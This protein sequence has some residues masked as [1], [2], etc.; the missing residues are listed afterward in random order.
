M[1]SRARH[2]ASIGCQRVKSLCGNLTLNRAA[3]EAVPYKELE[4]ITM[5][6][7]API[8]A[9][10]KVA[11]EEAAGKKINAM[12]GEARNRP[13][14]WGHEKKERFFASLRMTKRTAFFAACE[15]AAHTCDL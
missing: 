12:P 15:A 5:T 4:A 2:P 1:S 9:P 6:L 14:I 3:A 11:A 8:Y 13:S 10:L 7:K